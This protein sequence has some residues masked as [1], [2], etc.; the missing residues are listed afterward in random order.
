M[1]LRIGVDGHVLTGKF[2]GT[3]TTLSNLLRAV[4]SRLGDRQLVVYADDPEKARALL[5]TNAFA[6]RDL[7]RVPAIRRL[8]S[9][10][11]Q[12]FR[13]DGIDLGVFQYMAPLRGRH[14]VFVH[15]LLP[16][17]HPHLFPLKIRLRT[18]IFF[19]LAIRR[20]AMV[21]AVSDYTRGEIMRRFR[22]PSGKLRVVRNGPS[23]PPATYRQSSPGPKG[24]YIMTVGRIEPRKNIALLV[25]AFRKAGVPGVRLVI[26]G[27]FDPDFPQV[28]IEGERVE[29]RSGVSDDE[30]IELYRGASLFVYPSEAEGFGMPLLDAILFGLPVI[31]SDRTSLPEVGGD[32]AAYFDPTAAGAVDHLAAKIAGHFGD[33][34][35]SPPTPAQREAHAARFNWSRAAGDFLDAIDAAQQYLSAPAGKAGVIR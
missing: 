25:D 28:R 34:P 22:L 30:L 17:T 32:L 16:L 29:V 2:Q 1:T 35:L 19:S 33:A 23:F 24:R 13:D 14:I 11:P 26:V 6:Y 18:R 21:L 31:S 12:Q 15:D 4:A 8:L 20:A 5:G 9:V 7:G 27:A 3:R 10:L